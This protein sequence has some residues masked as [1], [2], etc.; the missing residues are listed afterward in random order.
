MSSGLV[1]LSVYV[2]QNQARKLVKG[3]PIQLSHSALSQGHNVEMKV[4]PMT[5]KKIQRALRNKKGSRIQLSEQEIMASGILDWLKNAASW[6]KKNVIDTPFYQE[7]IRPIA[8]D[9]VKTGVSMIPGPQ[10]ARD[11]AQRGVDYL[12]EKS[13]AFGMPS[14]RRRKNPTPE[15]PP[16]PGIKS[17]AGSFRLQGKGRKDL[18][19]KCCGYLTGSSFRLN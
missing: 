12:S 9:L 19:E 2:S 14:N 6:V 15:V 3:K 10:L 8:R 7:K 16:P 5:Y 11:V 17:S 1:P 4:H 18:C 13:S